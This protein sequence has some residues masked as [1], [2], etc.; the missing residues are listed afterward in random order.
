MRYALFVIAW[1]AC[2][3]AESVAEPRA[4]AEPSDRAP[5]VAEPPGHVLAIAQDAPVG[6]PSATVD[7]RTAEGARLVG[8]AWR[9]ADVAID[10][11]ESPTVGADLRASGPPGRTRDITPR[12]GRGWEE[13]AWQ[14]IEP[15]TL[16]ARR[17]GGHLSFGWYR[18]HLE[19]P[20]RIA[21]QDVAGA[22][23]AF[24]IV[25]D[26]YA[27][28]WV[29]GRL[30][31]RLGERGAAVV[32]G[33][34]APN[35]VIL[36]RD[37]R[38]GQRFDVAV[39]AINGPVSASP[40]NFLWVRSAVLDLYREAPRLDDRAELL[41]VERL[42]PE[43]DRIVRAGAR[44]ERLATGFEFIEGPLW[45]PD[46]TLL[47]SDPNANLI[48]RYDPEGR[49]SVFR[50]HSGY[51]GADIASYHQPGSNGLTLDAEGRVT[52][53]EHGNR[54][55]TRLERN[56]SLTVLADR[57]EGHR[58]N[59]PNDL[60]YGPDGS[61]YFT[62]PPFGLPRVYDDP[63]KELD[64]CGVMRR[65]PDGTIT[66]LDRSLR[67]PNGIAITA[68][69]HTL[70]VGN[71]DEERKVVMRYPLNDDGTL[72]EGSVFLDLADEEGEEAIDGVDV[73]R[74]GHVYVSGPGGVW[75]LAP[76][77]RRLGVL[78]MAELPANFAWGGED[79]RDFYM[80]ARTSLYRVRLGI[81]GV[82][83]EPREEPH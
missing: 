75:I 53:N 49:L 45:M 66:A 3:H 5:E 34:N 39:F 60:I 41:R 37:A 73:D 63:G 51:T 65:A 14:A 82:R 17:G 72:G 1:T 6:P 15:E 67:G 54:R 29:D 69:G 80:T 12:P 48:Y 59:S 40:Q 38:P 55:V 76:D 26:D 46:G 61:L 2:G 33:F 36:T 35:R 42:D 10:E 81:A 70:Y 58:L 19:L 22:T 83:P 74:E 68:D 62:D 13:A 9:Y 30:A 27:E 47:F 21:E 32:A 18:T 50:S 8:A 23:V 56:G 28:V 43:L 25:V 31:P 20:A 64:F 77:G 57:F 4:N 52:I 16:E 78:R 7:L 44:A 24:E 11:I 79:A 71:W